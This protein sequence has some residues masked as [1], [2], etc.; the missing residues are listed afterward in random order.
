MPPLALALLLTR[1]LPW[2]TV[3]GRAVMNTLICDNGRVGSAEAL[4]RRLGLRS[5]FQLN[6]LLR[7]EGLPPYEELAGWVCVFYWMLKADAEPGGDASLRALATTARMDV[8]SCYRLVRRVSGRCWTQL[9]GAGT[10][11]V[12]ALFRR[13]TQPRR[14][15]SP[16]S[17]ART[18]AR[19]LP[20]PAPAEPLPPARDRLIRVAL[21][22][23]PYGVAVRGGDLAYVTRTRGAAIERLDLAVGRRGGTI[24]LGC[25][26][27]CVAFAPSG[28]LAYVSLQYRDE[29]AVVDTTQHRQTAALR[30]PGDP[31]P[32]VLSPTG[33]TL[34]VTTNEDR[35]F[36][37]CPSNGRILGSLRLPATSH[38]LALH[39]A[40]GR[41]YV[42]T[43]AAGSV[44]EVDTSRLEVLRTFALGGWPQ[45]VAVSRDGMLLYCANE[46]HGLDVVR[47][48]TG[49]RIA[50]LALLQG[51]VSL[52]LSPDHRWLYTGLVHAGKVAV[53]DATTFETAAVL[54]LG[55]HP[56]EFGFDSRGGRVIVANEAGWIDLLPLNGRR[57]YHLDSP[58]QPL[59]P[60]PLTGSPRHVADR[61]TY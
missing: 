31:F 51:A 58:Q 13:R 55:G 54:D 8:A 36:S 43:R 38:H 32:L 27:T 50:R 2:L 4:C 61:M 5:R 6:R 1:T 15:T 49:K 10:D 25:T 11:A 41:I 45:G 39:P 44:L 19:G 34:F 46:H 26:P 17:V 18:P 16:S 24:P 9:R 14:M 22:G 29:I 59:T 33:R 20:S 3:D 23:G 12:V 35:L 42:A 7:R 53:V 28:T 56:R 37:L 40:G 30:V 52:A 47:L 48:A 60:I 21:D 57:V